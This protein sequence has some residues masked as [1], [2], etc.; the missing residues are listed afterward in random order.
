MKRLLIISR[1]HEPRGGADQIIADL[2][3]HLPEHGWQARLALTAGKTFNRPENYKSVYPDLEILPVRG[4]LGTRRQRLQSLRRVIQRERPSVVLGMRVFD[5]F[6]AIATIK[7]SCK[8]P[9]RFALGIRAF[10]PGYLQDLIDFGNVVD[11][12]MTSGELIAQSCVSIGTFP[13]D[14]VISIPGGV[15]T[16]AAL[17]RTPEPDDRIR[18][19]Y[20]GRL[21]QAQKRVLDLCEITAQLRQHGIPFQL[22]ICG[23]GPAEEELRL[24]L[25]PFIQSGQVQFHGW[26]DKQTLYD[27]HLPA[28]DCFIHTAAFEGVTIAPREAMA[29]GVVPVISQF[30]GLATE[31][32][33][34]HGHNCLTFPVGE[35]SEATAAITRLHHDRALW[36]RLSDAA[37]LSQQGKY[38][39]DGAIKTWADAF[40]HCLDLPVRTG[41]IPKQT[42][43]PPGRLSQLGLSEGLQHWIRTIAGIPVQ[44]SDPGSEWPT[45]SQSANAAFARRLTDFA[46]ACDAAAHERSQAEMLVDAPTMLEAR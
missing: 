1:C 3:R 22:S 23:S 2:C 30:R 44:H 38:S 21:E 29:H 6:E 43:T 25:E 7:S 28:A 14:R 37:V 18:L 36:K 24:R 33:F 15:R 20:A 19:L 39:F 16:P 32:Q 5:L 46:E 8:Q 12:C 9:P 40:S 31:G 17:R 34:R 10:E 35:L 45:N 4:E 41:S 13:Q 27:Q 11:Y 26:C 42:K